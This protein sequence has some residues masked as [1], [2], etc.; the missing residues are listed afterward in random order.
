MED[1]AITAMVC[2]R[3]ESLT[4]HIK[5]MKLINAIAA[6]AVIGGSLIAILPANA[7]IQIDLEGDL[8]TMVICNDNEPYIYANNNKTWNKAYSTSSFTKTADGAVARGSCDLIVLD[9]GN[10][11]PDDIPGYKI[12]RGEKARETTSMG[13][14]ILFDK[15]KPNP[16]KYNSPRP[17]A[18][19]C[20]GQLGDIP[21]KK[22]KTYCFK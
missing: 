1:K 14:D 7:S 12:L 5:Q 11:F 6:A 4:H 2:S 17:I 10:E 20:M 9:T 22:V 8:K 16:S 3:G 21:I 18:S 15:A 13:W 19:A